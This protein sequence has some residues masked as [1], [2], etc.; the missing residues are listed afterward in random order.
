MILHPMAE[1]NGEIEYLLLYY[2]NSFIFT[3]ILMQK[4]N[5]MTN[6]IDFK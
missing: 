6:T 4:L 3:L 1:V 2:W 5:V